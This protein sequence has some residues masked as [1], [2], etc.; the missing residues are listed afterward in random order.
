MFFK[1]GKG[2]KNISLLNFV[3]PQNIT[4]G[5]WEL[6]LNLSL[7]SQLFEQPIV[8]FGGATERE[9]HNK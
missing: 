1:R 9:L 2:R 3:D 4:V 5:C 7:P 8:I 6:S